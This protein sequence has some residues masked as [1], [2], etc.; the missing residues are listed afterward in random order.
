MTDE[1]MLAAF[2]TAAEKSG[3]TL[4]KGAEGAS[5]PASAPE[6]P[7]AWGGAPPPTDEDAPPDDAAP[8]RMRSLRAAE[9][10]ADEAQRN[11]LMSASTFLFRDNAAGDAALLG[12]GD[13]ALHVSGEA[14]FVVAV[15]GVGKSTFAQNYVLARMGLR[16]TSFIGLPV[17][18]LAE[19]EAVLYLAADRPKQ[20]HRSML[21]MVNED[22]A[23]ALDRH[24]LFWKG[25]P[26]FLLNREP[27]QLLDFIHEQEQQAGA[28][29]AEIVLDSLK[30]VA[31]ELAK[32]EGGSG[33][34]QAINHVIA[35]DREVMVLHHERKSERGAKRAPAHVEDVY[36][37]QFLTSCAGNVVYLFGEPGAHVLKLH[38]LK[39]SADEVGPWQLLHDHDTG[40]ITL[41]A[42]RDLAALVRTG[43][44]VTV[45]DACVHL[46][47]D[48]SPDANTQ[49]KARRKLDGLVKKG[50]ARKV[51]SPSQGKAAPAHWYP[52]DREAEARIPL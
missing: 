29:I 9:T 27:L 40:S 6:P 4:P 17:K 2:R 48:R 38:H 22:D 7:P 21:R 49:A 39:Q 51:S 37:S 45:K 28:R 31:L 19:G 3:A 23:E 44:G 15:T 25:P 10:G 36:G 41:D 34:A 18:P 52:V 24:L 14:T 50:V 8:T 13:Q 11:R 26:P 20:V 35:D 43:R 30:D 46:W 12:E 5:E 33:V 16:A 47:D 1:V 32:D 42:E